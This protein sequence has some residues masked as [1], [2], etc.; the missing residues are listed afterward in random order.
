MKKM[1]TVILL[2]LALF[3][4]VTVPRPSA[5][6]RA[7]VVKLEAPIGTGSGVVIGL[8]ETAEGCDVAIATARH[9]VAS[10]NAQGWTP[11]DTKLD[12]ISP[13]TVA[14]H[15]KSDV[16]F[17]MYHLEKSCVETGYK[18]MEMDVT[19]LKALDPLLHVGYPRGE[20]MVGHATYVNDTE[21][22]GNT[23]SAITSVAG[24]GSSG[25][26]ILHR[27]KLVGILVAGEGL[28]P[29]RNYFTP[30]ARLLEILPDLQTA[31]G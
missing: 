16:A 23:V 17:A 27:G 24:P 11:I 10:P 4:C 19:P 30:V 26:A 20:Y 2:S 12:D 8:T 6:Y 18:V 1:L 15:Y 29:F 5:D 7:S 14:P 9:V 28:P 25:G 3:A 31:R 13:Y 22:F 21:V